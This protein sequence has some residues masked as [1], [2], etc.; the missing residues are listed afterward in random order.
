MTEAERILVA[1]DLQN[2]LQWWANGE[3]WTEL[4]RAERAQ[5]A[6]KQ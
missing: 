3:R 2:K 4:I 5:K 1:L 6:R